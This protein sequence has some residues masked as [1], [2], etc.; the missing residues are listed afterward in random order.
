M[1]EPAGLFL[2]SRE[3]GDMRQELTELREL[4]AQWFLDSDPG[5][6]QFPRSIAQSHRDNSLDPQPN[7]KVFP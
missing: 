6:R 1:S 3:F 5:A 4:L 7:R 2:L